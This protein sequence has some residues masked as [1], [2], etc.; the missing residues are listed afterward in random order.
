MLELVDVS[1]KVVT[2]STAPLANL[3]SSV[4]CLK[5]SVPILAE[6]HSA[7]YL[8]ILK[9]L[10]PLLSESALPSEVSSLYQLSR[11]FDQP[12]FSLILRLP[13]SSSCLSVS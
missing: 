13:A 3:V 5:A 6:G 2:D 10:L 9:E 11:P 4:Q 7:K 1:V 12:F 8:A